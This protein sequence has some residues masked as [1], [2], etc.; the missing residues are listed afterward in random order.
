MPRPPRLDVPGLPQHLVARGHD[1]KE[2]FRRE[3]DRAVYLRYLREA[4]DK[5]ECEVHAY[6][7]MTNH[8]HLLATGR[9]PRSISRLMQFVG[10]RYCR[11]VNRVYGRTGALFEGRFKSSLVD[12]E[13]YLLAC[14]RYIEL[15]PVR[16]GMVDHPAGY[17]WSSFRENASGDPS[18]LVAPHLE[19]L[20]LGGDRGARR[21]AYTAL[22]NQPLDPNQLREIRHAS[23]KNGVLGDQSFQE[24]LELELDREVAIVAPGRPRKKP[25]SNL[26]AEK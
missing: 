11:Y 7:L 17:S 8:V 9:K 26:G 15:N 23:A 14:M 25:K 4:L 24:A 18:G 5:S 1:R 22:L 3:F 6:V 19:Y 2:C 13:A 20:R 10:R 21:A 12:S 16:A